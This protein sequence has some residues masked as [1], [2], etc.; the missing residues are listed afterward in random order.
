MCP[1]MVKIFNGATFVEIFNGTKS[2]STMVD[3]DFLMMKWHCIY[4]VA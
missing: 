1:K 3:R 4:L 2:R